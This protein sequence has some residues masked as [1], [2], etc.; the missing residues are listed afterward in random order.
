MCFSYSLYINVISKYI[1]IIVKVGLDII[2]WSFSYFYNKLFSLWGRYIGI[3]LGQW[4][5]PDICI[6]ILVLTMRRTEHLVLP[7]W[8]HW[9]K[10]SSQE[11]LPR[12][13]DLFSGTA[14]KLCCSV[15]YP[16]VHCFDNFML[17]QNIM[18][19]KH[20]ENRFSI[21]KETP[22]WDLSR[23][24]LQWS[25]E[26]FLLHNKALFPRFNFVIAFCFL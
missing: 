3:W 6:R 9:P 2:N 20:A 14:G 23:S 26:N 12:E 5:C 10:S 16:R 25:K 4:I 15:N 22:Q 17:Q 11:P 24:Y 13:S 18:Y 19:C 8:N 21:C 7:I 1:I